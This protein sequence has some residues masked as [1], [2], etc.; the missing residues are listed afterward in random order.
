MSWHLQI[1]L[2]AIENHELFMRL[3]ISL[4]HAVFQLSNFD[5]HNVTQQFAIFHF[6]QSLW[7]LAIFSAWC[8]IHDIMSGACA[9]AVS[10]VLSR[11]NS[12]L[13][14][15][16]NEC[17][18][19]ALPGRRDCVDDFQSGGSS[20]LLVRV[21]LMYRFGIFGVDSVGGL[22]CWTNIHSSTFANSGNDMYTVSLVVSIS[23]SF[24]VKPRVIYS[25]LNVSYYVV[26]T[27]C[28]LVCK[29]PSV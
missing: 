7:W 6:S 3:D 18:L 27:V 11:F 20:E 24:R 1:E 19:E 22:S 2:A 28:N 26:F 21:Y 13:S 10:S 5:K 4:K 9:L 12:F 25:Y 23:L 16:L 14:S 17:R 29:N 15:L 8:T